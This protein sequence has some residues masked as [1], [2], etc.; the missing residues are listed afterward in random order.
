MRI[1]FVL[2]G[3]LITFLLLR[4]GGSNG[5]ISLT[6]FF[7]RR[8]LRILPV[9]LLFL[10]V[11]ASLQFASL[12]SDAASSWI[13]SLTYTRNIIGQGNRATGH[14]WSLAVEEQFYFAWPAALV[15]I[16]LTNRWRL[17]V[18]LLSGVIV[19]SI[20]A[21]LVSCGVPG[22]VCQRLLGP[23]SIVL[24]ADSLAIGCI[25]AYIYTNLEFGNRLLR[26]GLL[27]LSLVA[28]VLS[29]ILVPSDKILHS[30]LMTAQGVLILTC[31]VLSLNAHGTFLFAVLNSRIIV[32]LG[33]ISYSLYI[34]HVLFL[35]GYMGERIWASVLYDGRVWWMP[36]IAIAALSYFL[37]ERPVL[38]LKDRLQIH[39]CAAAFPGLRLQSV[40]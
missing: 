7:I 31:L 19:V 22:F 20:I 36:S 8:A 23:K 40:G 4:E 30:V 12:Y 9:Y 18:A 39:P 13:G 5:F 38:R 11:L 32:F 1:F 10:T 28:L 14:L 34:W 24:Y 33:L 35:S 37:F 2:S 21:R 26:A 17:A 16:G 27:Y 3:F 25:G 6:N 15:F 29:A